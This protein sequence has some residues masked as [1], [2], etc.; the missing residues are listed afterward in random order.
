M[1]QGLPFELV[2]ALRYIQANLKQSFIVMLAV[3]IGVALIIFIPSVNMGFYNR[4]LNRAVEKSAHI[5]ITREIKTGPRNQALLNQ[6]TGPKITVRVADKTL[7][8]KRDII[9]WRSLMAR[10]A[11]IPGVV[12][13]SPYVSQN[14]ILVRGSK[15]MGA[16]LQGIIPALEQPVSRV[17]D[18]VAQGNLSTLKGNQVFLGWRLAEELGVKVGS[19]VEMV[20]P[21]GKR[22][23]KV[24]GLI[25]S[26]LVG[27]DLGTALTDLT[28]AQKLLGMSDTVTG[29]GLKVADPYG[30]EVIAQQIHARFGLKAR[31]WMDENRLLLEELKG[32]EVIVGFINFLIVFAAASSITSILIM[33]VSSKSR[34]IGIIKAMGATAPQIVRLFLIQAAFLSL[35]GAIA[36]IVLGVGLIELY[37]AT[38]YARAETPY[39][40][41]MEPVTLNIR[42][43]VQAVVYALI[44]SFLASFIPAWQAGRLNPVDAINQ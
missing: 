35:M 42:F 33:V 18:D 15:T 8:R 12:A 11:K 9:A 6:A 3:G 37:N 29:L 38:P 34:E 14:V 44:S 27:K 26:G 30:A 25:R 16:S 21:E 32:F 40:F 2:V 36:G 13:G 5:T 31:S 1:N 17:A 43:T 41:S 28:A 4:L 10:L 20:T 7:S 22:S 23:F 24:V 19:R 39:G